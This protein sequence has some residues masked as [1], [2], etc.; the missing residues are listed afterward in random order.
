MEIKGGEPMEG[1]ALGTE[2]IGSV[3]AYL[4]ASI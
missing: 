2:L 4:R 3:I 1:I